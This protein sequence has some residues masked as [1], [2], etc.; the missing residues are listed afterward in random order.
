M[1]EGAVAS[2]PRKG[3]HPVV[4]CKAGE[5][6]CYK[7]LKTYILWWFRRHRTEVPLTILHRNLNYVMECGVINLFCSIEWAIEGGLCQVNIPREGTPGSIGLHWSVL[8]FY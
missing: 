2:L 3:V 4:V 8:G 7:G 5:P 6:E 1:I